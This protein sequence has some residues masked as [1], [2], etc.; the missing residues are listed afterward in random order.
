M[1]LESTSDRLE[2]SAEAR[3]ERLARRVAALERQ[4]EA[5]IGQVDD[6]RRRLAH[7]ERQAM[8]IGSELESSRKAA[9][10]DAL[11]A[12]FTMR[13]LRLPRSVYGDVRRRLRERR[14]AAERRR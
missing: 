5:R 3:A 6:L 2:V 12:T 9:E 10:Y 1:A 8:P 14:R 4:V 13:A 11:M 7:A